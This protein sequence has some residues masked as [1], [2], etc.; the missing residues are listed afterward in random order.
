LIQARI[1]DLHAFSQL[2][3]DEEHRD[4]E[5]LCVV[6]IDLPTP[7]HAYIFATINFN[8]KKVDRS[9][10]YPVSLWQPGLKPSK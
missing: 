5:L 9:L 8:Q 4:M 2:A 3:D 7:Y 6:F 1:V 10:T